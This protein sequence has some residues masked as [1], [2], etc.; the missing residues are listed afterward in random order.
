MTATDFVLYTIFVDQIPS[1]VIN[2]FAMHVIWF[3]D[4][5][6][7]RS[8]SLQGMSWSSSYGS[9]I[10]NYL[11]NQSLSPLK[12]E[13]RSWRGVLD[14]TLCDKV[15]QSLATGRWFSPGIPVSSTNKTDPHDIGEILLK[16]ALNNINQTQTCT[17]SALDLNCSCDIKITEVIVTLRYT[18]FISLLLWVSTQPSLLYHW[19]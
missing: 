11:C 18:N 6:W 14:T 15:C 8:L 4:K 17:P 3:Y 16:V 2:I 5:Y 13:P 9:W 1:L 12:F 10:Y 7:Y 19:Q